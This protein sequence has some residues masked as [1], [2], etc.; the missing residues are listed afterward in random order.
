[1]LNRFAILA[2]ACIIGL[3]AASPARALT[4]T[5]SGEGWCNNVSGCNNTNTNV[6]ANT[7]AGNNPSGPGQPSTSIYRDWF[8]FNLPLLGAPIT[9]A[10]ISIWNEGSNFN[11]VNPSAVFNLYEATGI[12][13]AGLTNGPSLGSILVNAAD[14]GVDHF[15]DITFNAAGIT[16]LNAN[17]GDLLI[18][19]GNN[20]FGEQIFGYTSGVP[21]AYILTVETAVPAPAGLALLVLGLGLLSFRVR[22]AQ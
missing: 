12:S 18:L 19:G 4:V 1:M 8:A 10:T 2:T 13:F 7:F 14:T 20:D 22:R 16:A 9:T 11:T 21:V 5:A 15:V 17:Q 6:I 3:A